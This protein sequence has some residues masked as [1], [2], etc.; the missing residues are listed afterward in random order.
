MLETLAVISLIACLSLSVN[1]HPSDSV[2]SSR[3]VDDDFGCATADGRA[4]MCT[5][6]GTCATVKD[7]TSLS[8]CNTVPLVTEKY[9]CCPFSSQP[10]VYARSLKGK[11]CLREETN[12]LIA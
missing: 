10:A 1:C 7:E 5:R 11:R 6:V 8:V 12:I 3:T 9:I 4:G 2:T